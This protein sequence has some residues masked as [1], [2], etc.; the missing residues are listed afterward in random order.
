MRRNQIQKSLFGLLLAITFLDGSGAI[1]PFCGS[2]RR[3]SRADFAHTELGK[4]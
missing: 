2:A 1:T 4:L 3:N